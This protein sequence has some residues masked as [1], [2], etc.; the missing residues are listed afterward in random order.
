M[1]TLPDL[2]YIPVT[3][4]QRAWLH[5]MTTHLPQG[6]HSYA[7]VQHCIVHKEKYSIIC[8]KYLPMSFMLLQRTRQPTGR[9]SLSVQQTRKQAQQWPGLNPALAHG[10]ALAGEGQ[11]ENRRATLPP[12]PA[13]HC[14]MLACWWRAHVCIPSPTRSYEEP[15]PAQCGIWFSVQTSI[16]IPLPLMIYSVTVTSGCNGK[17]SPVASFLRH[18]WDPLLDHP[19]VWST[20]LGCFQWFSWFSGTMQETRQWALC[21]HNAVTGTGRRENAPLDQKGPLCS[22]GV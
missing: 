8:I 19:M 6:Q 12:N 3:C 18:M 2:L 17:F 14:S 16:R 22:P 21:P 5:T 7:T 9:T 10:K 11:A 20:F 4:K 13:L 15:K 1:H